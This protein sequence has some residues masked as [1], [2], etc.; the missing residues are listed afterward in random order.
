MKKLTAFLMLILI[1]PVL[2]QAQYLGGNGNGDA[3]VSLVNAHILIRK[4]ESELPSKYELYQNYPNPFN[5]STIIRF[6]VK[7]P[8]LV[9]LKI[10][11]I[12]GKEIATLVNEDLKAGTYEVPFSINQYSGNQVSS[13][14]Y[15]YSLK[16]EN[17]IL[18]R[19]MLLI[20]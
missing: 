9:S 1:I 8:G 20:K 16:T 10:Y 14:I 13:C 18:T 5:P 7:E 4:I 19:N 2:L 17:N 6:Q 15:F 12:L 3:T 11:D